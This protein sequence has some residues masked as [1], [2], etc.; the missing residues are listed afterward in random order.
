MRKVSCAIVGLLTAVAGIVMLTPL[1]GFA[2]DRDDLVSQQE[3][4]DRQIS[5][6]QAQLEGVDTELQKIIVELENTRS[7]VP[8]AEAKLA[9]AER[10]VSAA[11]RKVEEKA[12]LLEAAQKELA[13]ITAQQQQADDLAGESRESLGALARAAYRGDTGPSTLDLIVGSSSAED[14]L[15]AF[16]ANETIARTQSAAFTSG[17][18]TGAAARNGAARQKAVEKTIADLK[19]EADAVLAE[20]E[21]AQQ[22]AQAERTKLADLEKQINAQNAQLQ[23]RKGDYEASLAQ[24][25][26]ER[27]NLAAQIAQIDAA[28]RAGGNNWQP[29]AGGGAYWLMPPIPKPFYMTSSFGGRVHPVTGYRTFHY[30]V[31][32]GSPCGQLQTAGAAGTVVETVPAHLGGSGGAQVMI[33]HGTVN[34]S[35]WVTV[36]LHLSAINV[37]PGQRV[38]QGT[39]I[40]RTGA[41][42]RVTGCHVHYEVWQNGT[43][44][45]PM[46]LPSFQ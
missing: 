31:D 5:S 10:A 39:V 27:N 21:S 24:V 23:A 14:F 8:A 1:G 46:S 37:S 41:T 12:A 28:N 16:L 2:A 22:A 29:A 7:Q 34:G 13:D 4:K 45:N 38:A 44:I 18:Q 15:A 32:L 36:H 9:Q 26:T 19:A 43:P 3:S 42:G 20:K 30:G 17:Q 33:N 11:E 6:L 40:G 35:S 25:K